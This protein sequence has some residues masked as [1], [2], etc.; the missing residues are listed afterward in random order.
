MLKL[1]ANTQR[2]KNINMFGRRKMHEKTSYPE[3]FKLSS[4]VK[5]SV[6]IF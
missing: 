4:N 5:F 1:L 3:I 2:L 6:K